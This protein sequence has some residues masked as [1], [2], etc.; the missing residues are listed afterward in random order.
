MVEEELLSTT[1]ICEVMSLLH[2]TTHH[3]FDPSKL[4]QVPIV[5][6]DWLGIFLNLKII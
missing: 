3:L 6:R 4:L 1:H 2:K 5:P